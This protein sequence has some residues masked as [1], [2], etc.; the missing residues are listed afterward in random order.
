MSNITAKSGTLKENGDEELIPVTVRLHKS[1]YNVLH[2]LAEKFDV[3]FSY[4]SRLAIEC[5]LE[6]YLGTIRY[7]DVNQGERIESIAFEFS[8]TCRNILNNVRRI[9]INYNQEIRL[10]NAENKYRE[11][12]KK[13]VGYNEM[14][15]AKNEYNAVQTEIKETCLDKNEFYTLLTQFE[16]AVEKVG[17]IAWLILL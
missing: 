14:L 13:S 11:T 16:N 12:L 1:N 10:K 9:G 15:A 17:D 4:V 5:E 7:I 3:S 2:E 8:R 6:K